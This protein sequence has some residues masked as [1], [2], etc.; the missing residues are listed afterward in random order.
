MDFEKEK[1]QKPMKQENASN[2]NEK[3][4]KQNET[5]PSSQP[6]FRDSL[7]TRAVGK[8]NPM[9]SFSSNK[10]KEENNPSKDQGGLASFFDRV[11][12]NKQRSPHQ[13]AKEKEPEKKE[14]GEE[15]SKEN[16]KNQ[17]EERTTKR[18][19]EVPRGTLGSMLKNKITN[20]ISD[21]RKRGI[22]EEEHQEEN[23]S[24]S[25]FIQKGI[26]KIAGVLMGS[27]TLPS[28]LPVVLIGSLLAFFGIFTVTTTATTISGSFSIDYL[29][30]QKLGE[31]ISGTQVDE[32]MYKQDEIDFVNRIM[33][34][35]NISKSNNRNFNAHLI[36]GTQFVMQ[37]YDQNFD[38][39]KMT[40]NVIQELVNGMF[41]ENMYK[42]EK[43]KETLVSS[44]LPKYL[45]SID[46]GL[47]PSIADAILSHAASYKELAEIEEEPTTNTVG[48]TCTYVAP[49]VNIGG[50]RRSGSAI[51]ASNIQVQL[52]Q[53]G[54]SS[55]H[56]YGG[57]SGEKMDVPL[58]PFEEYA[59][60]V[61][62]QEVGPGVQP[63]TL[64]AQNIAARSYSLAR[65]FDMGG[66]RKLAFEN[67]QWILSI[68]SSTADQ[69]YCSLKEGCSSNKTTNSSDACQWGMIYP[70]T[71][72]GTVC[73]GPLEEGHE[74]YR[75]QDEMAGKVVVD[76]EGYIV[77]T[78]YKSGD[79]DTWDELAKS[80]YNYTQ[81]LLSYYASRGA[82]E[83]K[84]MACSG[85]A[86]AGELPWK[87]SDPRWG[88]IIISPSQKTLS[89]I[90][91][92]ITSL[93]M[94]VARSGVSTTLSELNPGTFA[95]A[96]I[97]LGTFNSSGSLTDFNNVTKIAPQ[98]HVYES[99]HYFSGSKEYKT[100]EIQKYLQQGYF[101]IAQVTG[102]ETNQHFVY[103]DSSDGENVSILDP[104]WNHTD[105]WEAYDTER[106]VI[107]KKG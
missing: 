96:L 52:M 105:L 88:S 56:N 72:H 12:K 67:N 58:I 99:H 63:A 48:G 46:A 19:E 36:T 8:R 10:S 65:P 77:Y 62:Y 21:F 3:Q 29:L 14:E 7:R 71:N 97:D 47:Y 32:S 23:Q 80:G 83:I 101:L 66:F 35:Y 27:I 93:A 79:Q 73:K 20:S 18:E 81:I 5:L 106:L 69:V 40:S 45:P 55:G 61:V 41:E 87:Q 100:K 22:L 86:A 28:L 26:S 92:L 50:T 107:F 103:I 76:S 31:E 84:Q 54:T 91:C 68:A 9:A 43:F 95:Q 39:N 89:S 25:N 60:G 64:R 53:T 44:F 70:G 34:I 85:S 42:E 1:E 13:N 17:T 37:Q 94:M 102:P 75:V 2:Q 4:R 98:L 104:G 78:G 74:L 6:P 57:T 51:N 11:N 24:G 30:S 49:G 16:E 59:A 15:T 90:G 38:D 33:S 82:A